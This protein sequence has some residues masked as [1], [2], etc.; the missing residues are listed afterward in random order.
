MSVALLRL[1]DGFASQS[2]HLRDDVRRLQR[3][4]QQAGYS[5]EADGLCGPATKKAVKAFQRDHRLA[6]DGVVGRNTWKT[7]EKYR[8]SEEKAH[9][10][11]TPVP[12]CVLTDFR[13]DLQW[14][15]EREGHAGKAY[16]PG[17]CSGVT[18]DPGVDLGHVKP[19]LIDA[20]YRDLLTLE[21]VEA[22]KKVLGIKGREAKAFLENDPVLQSIR[23]SRPDAEVI[24][25]Y[26]VQPYWEAI[27]K[28]F[29]TLAEPETLPVVQTT[30][31]SLAYNRGSWNRGLDV[32]REP[33][34][35]KKWSEVAERIGSM[36]Q[37]HR[38]KGIGKRRR[39]EADLIRQALA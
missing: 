34:E 9:D 37:G 20:A 38:L 17:G 10:S 4:L 12:S 8:K 15:H 26:A 1:R 14:V 3:L 19:S 7:L 24:F 28:R 27:V 5:V 21:Q 11:A 30:V 25:Q 29:P 35:S 33:L 13:G 18:L 6:V 22:A 16:W 36:Q 32:L 23:I 39:L 31:L 2:L